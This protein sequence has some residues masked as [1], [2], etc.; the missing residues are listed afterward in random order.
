V[1]DDSITLT[2]LEVFA[3]HGVHAAERHL[4]QRFVIDVTLWLDLSAAGASDDLTKTV[5]YGVLA[6]AI[7]RAASADPVDLIES[8]AERVAAIVLSNAAVQSTRVA[9]HKPSAPIP[10]PFGDVT[11]T[12]TRTRA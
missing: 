3:H 11:V 9:V 8:V 6:K 5:D 10:V 2:G 4:G 1:P 12:I 7:V